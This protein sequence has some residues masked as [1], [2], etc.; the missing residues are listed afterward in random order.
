MKQITGSPELGRA[1]FRKLKKRIN[2]LLDE[3]G[4][5]PAPWNLDVFVANVSRRRERPIEIKSIP[6]PP[7]GAD[8]MWIPMSHVDAILVDTAVA[9]LHREHILLHEISHM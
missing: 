8:A 5:V 4:L 9:G 6:M 3:P 1:E 2:A 7:G